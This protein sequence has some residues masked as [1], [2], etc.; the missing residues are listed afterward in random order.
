M[1]FAA[2]GAS[3]SFQAEFDTGV[4][5]Q[6]RAA[7]TGELATRTCEATLGWD[8]DSLIIATNSSQIDVDTFGV[9]LGLGVPV[10]TFK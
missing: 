6:A 8:K 7:K 9:D 4:T 10:A 5:V 1:Y 2:M 3:G